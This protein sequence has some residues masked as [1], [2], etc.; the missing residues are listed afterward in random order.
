MVQSLIKLLQREDTMDKLIKVGGWS[1]VELINEIFSEEKVTVIKG[2][3]V[4]ASD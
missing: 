1:K 3:I 4:L 2:L